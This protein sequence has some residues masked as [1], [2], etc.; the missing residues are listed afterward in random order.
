MAQRVGFARALVVDPELLLMDE[1][2]SALDVLTAEN[3]RS[4]LINIWESSATKIKS[5]LLVTHNIEEAAFLA[6]RIFVFATN[7]GHVAA[8]IKVAIKHPRDY[9]DPQFRQLID[10]IYTLMTRPAGAKIPLRAA[11]VKTIGLTY[12][13][14][15][16][17]ISEVIGFI[18]ELAYEYHAKADLPALAEELHLEIDSLFPLTESAGNFAFCRGFR[19]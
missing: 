14:P 1:P 9:Q 12:R 7:P 3:L 15:K 2:F 4:D 18:E 5:V 8:E 17:E 6:D 13:L 10:D 11:R 16:V 19:R